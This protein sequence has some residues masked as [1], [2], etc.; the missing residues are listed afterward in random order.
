MENIKNPRS[1]ALAGKRKVRTVDDISD[2]QFV[3]LAH[4]IQ[5]TVNGSWGVRALGAIFPRTEKGALS[6]L[7]G[8]VIPRR[9][10][11][12]RH[13][14]PPHLGGINAAH[15]YAPSSQVSR[16]FCLTAVI[17]GPCSFPSRIASYTTLI[18]LPMVFLSVDRK[19][20]CWPSSSGCVGSSIN[21][22]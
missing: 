10:V 11:L 6:Q 2:I 7:P 9:R 17:T 16:K 12:S 15:F 8:F 4:I 18:M 3:L 20:A 13:T 22:W 19:D 5:N 1:W 14:C 21:P